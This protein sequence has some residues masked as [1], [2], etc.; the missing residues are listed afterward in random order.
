MNFLRLP[1]ALVVSSLCA[2]SLVGCTG[3]SKVSKKSSRAVAT[4]TEQRSI[5]GESRKLASQPL[6]QIGLYLDSAN[7]ARLEL[8]SNPSNSQAQ[9][10][11][12]FAVSRIMEIIEEQGLTPWNQPVLCPSGASADW[13][14][15]FNSVGP[16]GKFSPGDFEILPTDRYEFNGKLV[17]ERR[18]K[19]GIGAPVMVSSSVRDYTKI[20]P[21]AQGKSIYYGLTAAVEF[22][23]KRCKVVLKD[24]LKDE[25]YQLDGHRYPLA[26]DFQAP[27]A[28]ALAEL[29]PRKAELAAMFNPSKHEGEARLARLQPYDPNKI[30][31][32]FIHGLS[33]SQAT[34]VPMI[35]TLRTDPVIRQKYQ[36]WVFTY[37]TGAPYPVPAAALRRQ[38]DQ[39]RK[40]HPDHKDMVVVGHSM[41]G[42]ISRILITDSG[43]TLW[44]TAFERPPGE[45]GFDEATRDTLSEWLIFKARPDISRV[46]YASASHRGSE[47]ATNRLGRLGARLVGN[48]VPGDEISGEVAAATRSGGKRGR[49]PN[50]IDV[51][52]PDSPFLLAVD[53]LPPKPGI[54]YH[55]LIGDR[56][57]GGNL[58]RTKPESSD[59]IVPY[60]SS[61]MD[62]AESELI[63]PSE[64]WT[65]LEP[66]GIAEVNRILHLHLK[67]E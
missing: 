30:P 41:G 12:N 15:E 63:I 60:W 4:T 47:G 25:T 35:E 16:H 2:L 50:S 61:H 34:W 51:L 42:M 37:P 40:Q 26:A 6:A 46:I 53:T 27:L 21:F 57:K 32:L 5:L 38:L 52:D 29:D 11:Y 65:I 23:G 13:V 59:G 33:N 58:D 62:G 17:G 28:L 48:P 14:L 3:Y 36:F 22:D 44:D 56:G 55:S 20:D 1:L 9:S 19:P 10:E 54:P 43:M 45:M 24:P 8:A 67:G 64:H 18:F 49:I 66:E 31:V 39:I 7:S